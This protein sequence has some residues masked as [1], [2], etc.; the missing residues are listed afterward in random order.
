[1]GLRGER[2]ADANRRD[3][4]AQRMVAIQPVDRTLTAAALGDRSI[5]GKREMRGIPVAMFV[6][7]LGCGGSGGGPLKPRIGLDM[8]KVAGFMLVPAIVTSSS[9]SLPAAAGLVP[10][11]LYAIGADGSLTV[12]SITTDARDLN[13]SAF[14]PVAIF[15]TK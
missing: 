2:R 13:K 4:T 12:V 1:M 8:S 7:C 11:V 14:R 15:D 9:N 3:R 5:D 6:A 10:T